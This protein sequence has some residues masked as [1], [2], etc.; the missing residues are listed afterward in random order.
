MGLDVEYTHHGQMHRLAAL[1]ERFNAATRGAIN[2][3]NEIETLAAKCRTGGICWI[4]RWRSSDDGS[5]SIYDCCVP[6][7]CAT[8]A[9]SAAPIASMNPSRHAWPHSEMT[10]R[11]FAEA[12]PMKR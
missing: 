11:V 5:S 4:R 1:Q 10:K 6:V 2:A 3:Q 7:S 12:S 8:A 9:L